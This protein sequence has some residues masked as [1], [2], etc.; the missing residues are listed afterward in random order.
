HGS[1]VQT[2][3]GGSS[4]LRV[5]FLGTDVG[6]GWG[7]SGI[8]ERLND[9]LNDETYM[10]LALRM[11]AETAGQTGV[12]PAVGCVVVKDGRIVGLGAHLKRGEPHAEVHAL[13]MAG[14]RSEGATV[15]VT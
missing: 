13:N 3:P 10:R 5:L 2:C 4:V 8:M 15:Y 7:R 12:N 6:A 14:E 11:A 9:R 1:R